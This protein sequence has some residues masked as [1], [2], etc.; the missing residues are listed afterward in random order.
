M[1]SPYCPLLIYRGE[2]DDAT[3]QTRLGNA[4]EEI[5]YGTETGNFELVRVVSSM[6]HALLVALVVSIFHLQM[7]ENAELSDA[8]AAIA[9]QLRAWYPHI[10]T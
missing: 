2:T 9:N 1:I 4:K 3:I 6:S 10:Q 7:V 5:A 8:V